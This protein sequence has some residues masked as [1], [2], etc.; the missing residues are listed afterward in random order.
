MK[1]KPK[2]ACH[3]YIRILAKDDDQSILICGTNAFQPMC[4][5]YEGE[6]YGD[7]TQS[8]EFSGLGI[9]P[10]DPNHNS[11]FLRDGDLLYAGTGNVHIIW[12]ISEPE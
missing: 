11:T 5:K 3:N 12:V 10:Y 1:G 8:L 6:K 4:R 7:Y 2:D 9:A